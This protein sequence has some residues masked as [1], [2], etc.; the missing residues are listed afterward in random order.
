M[1]NKEYLTPEVQVVAFSP[2]S[3]L[4]ASGWNDASIPD[5][6]NDVYEL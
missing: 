5:N 4:A 2:A 1:E 6:Y 3:V